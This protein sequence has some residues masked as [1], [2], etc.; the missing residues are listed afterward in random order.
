MTIVLAII[1]LVACS[2]LFLYSVVKF[3]DLISWLLEVRSQLRK[4]ERW[5]GKYPETF[6]S[7][8]EVYVDRVNRNADHSWI[9]SLNQRVSAIENAP[10]LAGKRPKTH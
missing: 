3:A 9:A 7:S 2:V 5:S 10:K 6:A 1:G 4:L 8:L